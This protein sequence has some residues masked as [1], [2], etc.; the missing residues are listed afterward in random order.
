MTDN[1]D[2]LRYRRLGLAK[3]VCDQCGETSWMTQE[4]MVFVTRS[5]LYEER[6]L[7]ADGALVC[8]LECANEFVVT[9]IGLSDPPGGDPMRW[10]VSRHD[11]TTILLKCQ[12][13]AAKA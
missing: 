8:S 11:G 3:I 1:G 12:I 5:D 2:P 4:Q 9:E 6:F 7:D 10:T 13:N